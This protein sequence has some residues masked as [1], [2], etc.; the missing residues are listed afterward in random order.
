MARL[1]L[2]QLDEHVLIAEGQIASL[3]L[4]SDNHYAQIGA[5]YRS[6]V[7]MAQKIETLTQL[8]AQQADV[9]AD[10][11]SKIEELTESHTRLQKSEAQTFTLSSSNARR[12]ELHGAWIAELFNR[13]NDHVNNDHVIEE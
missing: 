10:L 9:I 11:T 2:K 6:C 12:A 5:V 8:A 7:S 13:L 3:L 4:A 1:T